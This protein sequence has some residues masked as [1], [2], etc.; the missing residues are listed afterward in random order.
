MDPGVRV[1][2]QMDQNIFRSV[3]AEAGSLN[4]KYENLVGVVV[5][6]HSALKLVEEKLQ[7]LYGLYDSTI[8]DAQLQKV[9]YG[10]SLPFLVQ[11]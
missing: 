5:A 10:N 6:D 3:I 7:S 8:A 4:V 1:A 2:F 9:G 11:V